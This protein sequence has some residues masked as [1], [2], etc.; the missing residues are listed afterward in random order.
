MIVVFNM[1]QLFNVKTLLTVF[2]S[3]LVVGCVQS[4]SKPESASEI[5]KE[6]GHWTAVSSSVPGFKPSINTAFFFNDNLEMFVKGGAVNEERTT[7]LMGQLK[8]QMVD[9]KDVVFSLKDTSAFF[10]RTHLVYGDYFSEQEFI[11]KFGVAPQLTDS[12]TYQKGTLIVFIHNYADQVLW[13]GSVQIYGDPSLS[14]DVA[15]RRLIAAV[16]SL[17]DQMPHVTNP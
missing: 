14:D 1:L 3:L 12:A 7:F 16:A 6:L 15:R 5:P 13:R 9:Q 2:I 8:K 17:V 11:S 10:V 4:T